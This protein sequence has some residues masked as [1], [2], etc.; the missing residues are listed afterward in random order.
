MSD[1]TSK[2]SLNEFL[3]IFIPGL[4]I[5]ILFDLIILQGFISLPIISLSESY[6]TIFFIIFSLVSGIFLSSLDLPK[7][8]WF[9]KG[10]IPV[11]I[12][13]NKTD[14]KT[15]RVNITNL[16]FKFYDSEDVPPE[17]KY[18]TEKDSGFYHLC[19]NLAIVSFLYLIMAIF[20]YGILEP[21][22][23]LLLGSFIFSLVT[24][25][26]IFYLKVKANFQRQ[27]DMF[28]K[29]RFFKNINK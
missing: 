20:I 2:L 10:N 17:F 14:L 9:F 6:F 13:F 4:Y 5:S 25:L 1:F 29:S 12:L 23:L 28:K 8:L 24:S 11:N 16:Y 19:M 22:T 7:R 15:N 3:R 18:K 27:T 26:T 21:K